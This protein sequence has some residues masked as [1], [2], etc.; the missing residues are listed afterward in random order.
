MMDKR[1]IG[2][3][4]P[5]A[6][7][8]GTLSAYLKEKHGAVTFRFSSS[9][10][11]ILELLGMEQDR[12]HLSRLSRILREEFGEDA[13]AISLA[14]QV[15]KSDAPLIVVDGIRRPGDV[16]LLAKLPGFMMVYIDAPMETRFE[17][18]KLRGEKSDDAGKTYEEFVADHELETELLIAGLKDAASQVI[19]NSGTKEALFA[20]ADSLLS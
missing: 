11:S 13:L 17:R 15:V 6:S 5:L 9:L 2:I 20:Q 14:A 4:G 16:S 19:D 8:K 18:M 1:I 10:F 7:G 3:A 12:D